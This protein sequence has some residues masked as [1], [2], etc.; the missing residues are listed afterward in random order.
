[1]TGQP[2]R[3][4]E[5]ME[6]NDASP[7]AA[8][9]SFLHI[10]ARHR[11]V[12]AAVVLVCVLGAGA[13][14]ARRTPTYEATT[15]ILVSP[16][17][18]TD[19]ALLGLPL[20]RA[21]QLDPQRA[22]VTA[23]P[24]LDSPAT[25]RLVAAK[26]HMSDPNAISSAVTVAAVPN[27][28]L[29]QVTAEGSSADEAAAVANAYAEAALH[30]RAVLLAPQVRAAI[31]NTERQLESVSD[32]SGA[33]ANA[34]GVRLAGLRSI[35]S[36]G[37]PTLSVAR[38]S[39][40]GTPQDTPT[41]QVL[42]IALMAGAL[43]GGL[44]VV[45]IEL[46]VP[47]PINSEA[48]LLRLYPLPVL[49]RVPGDKVDSGVGSDYRSLS[50]APPAVREGFRTL[51]DQLELRAT[52]EEDAGAARGSTILMVSGEQSDVRGSCSLDLARA[53][54]SV[55]DAVAVVELDVRDPKMAAMLD[56]DPSGD[57]S[58]LLSGGGVGAIATPFDGTD[59]S[60]LIAAPRVIADLATREAIAAQ[61]A[62][63][64]D[65]ARRFSD[66]VVV[67]APPIV[68]AAADVIAALPAADF[69]V[70]VV[71]LGSTR[72]EA[73]DLLRELFEQRGRRPNGYLVVTGRSVGSWRSP[74]SPA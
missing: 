19:E 17:P 26:L 68:G 64:I 70:V 53:F 49:A 60:R 5:A 2:D 37:D 71:H 10:V 27:S 16:I 42:L 72:P 15:E 73:L 67:D 61:S 1:M 62:E 41:A 22:A 34:L 52:G 46:L 43:L 51:R 32:P 24:L 20:I 21:A 36:R 31:R 45:M 4:G 38:M 63:V 18:A 74:A 65:E 14:S 44:T 12:F 35:A 58:S 23:V 9:N 39:P 30:V 25:A 6:G 54:S 13:W 66:W 57:L 11:L 3:F 29:V 47:Q 48:E 40:P 59:G 8:L 7:A 50:D 33:E 28:S 56:V 55:H 69:M